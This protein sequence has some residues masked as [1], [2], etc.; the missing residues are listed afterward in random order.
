MRKR[1]LEEVICARPFYQFRETAWEGCEKSGTDPEEVGNGARESFKLKNK[2]QAKV[3]RGQ[4]DV[5]HSGITL[6]LLLKD[7]MEFK[8]VCSML[9]NVFLLA[10]IFTVI[11]Y[12][13]DGSQSSTLKNKAIQQFT[14]HPN[15]HE[16]V[17]EMTSVHSASM[18]YA[19]RLKELVDD[20]IGSTDR[21][22]D[23]DINLGRYGYVRGS[24]SGLRK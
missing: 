22:K 14:D 6:G 15:G 3:I 8:G 13:Y 21:T 24:A 20:Q 1:P 5:E 12:N 4:G 10:I 17:Y 18:F 11:E 2:P 23:N 9:Y 19:E 7:Y 16:T